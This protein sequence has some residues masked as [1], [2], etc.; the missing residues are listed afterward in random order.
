M[1][2][3]VEPLDRDMDIAG[4]VPDADVVTLGAGVPGILKPEMPR[5]FAQFP[6]SRLLPR[7]RR[8]SR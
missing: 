3:S 5:S 8:L 1:G 2:A 6:K 7:E 4:N